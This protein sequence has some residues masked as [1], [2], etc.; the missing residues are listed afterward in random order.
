MEEEHLVGV[1]G[2]DVARELVH[3]MLGGPREGQHEQE[4]LVRVRVRVRVRPYPYPYPYP[5]TYP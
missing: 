1:V 3:P 2:G 4:Q 5:Y